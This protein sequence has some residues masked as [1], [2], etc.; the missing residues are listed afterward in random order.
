MN[1]NVDAKNIGDIIKSLPY[2]AILLI[3]S[4]ISALLIFLPDTIL[5]RMFLLDFRDK[6]GTFLGIIFIISFCL[7]VYLYIS[8][9]IRSQRIKRALSGKKAIA[10]IS[11]LSSLEKQLV[12]YMYH[13][14]E[15][16]TFLPSSN[17]TIASLKHKLI[18]AETSNVGSMLGL[19]Q[20]YPFHLHPWVIETIKKKP[21]ILRGIPHGLPTI[22]ADYQ[23]IYSIPIM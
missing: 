17:P 10:K 18:I 16:T 9:F 8:S 21:D 11:E 3:I 23:D 13:N 22:F 7:T 2:K 20:I 15:K 5:K 6:I 4:I 19:E 1:V 14:P 12:C